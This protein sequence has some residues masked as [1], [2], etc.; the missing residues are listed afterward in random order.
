M[1]KEVKLILLIVV[2]TF[3]LFP[4]FV[5]EPLHLLAVTL[6]GGEGQIHIFT[7]KPF[8]DATYVYSKMNVWVFLFFPIFIQC[9][10]M[11][12]LASSKKPW[13]VGINVALA[14]DIGLQLIG[15]NNAMSDLRFI[16]EGSFY[17]IVALM[18]MAIAMS[19]FLFQ[20]FRYSVKYI[21]EKPLSNTYSRYR[22]NKNNTHTKDLKAGYPLK[23]M[24]NILVDGND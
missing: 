20:M 3:V 11:V 7:L 6:L 19:M 9:V 24:P 18:M 21:N 4:R 12:L 15:R 14:L 22:H 5:H 10:L 1:K 8:I 17:S 23:K 13:A 2:A 16:G